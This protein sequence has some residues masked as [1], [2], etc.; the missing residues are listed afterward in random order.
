M[1]EATGEPHEG[2]SPTAWR[3]RNAVAHALESF[4]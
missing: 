1:D 2:L 3:V 4:R